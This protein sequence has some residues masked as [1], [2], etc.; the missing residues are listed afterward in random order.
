MQLAYCATQ[1]RHG[2]VLYKRHER[3]SPEKGLQRTAVGISLT[4]R[5][6]CSLNLLCRVVFVMQP[7]AVGGQ[8]ILVHIV[9]EMSHMTVDVC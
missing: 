7:G 5:S 8:S 4:R 6:G 3:F 9:L 1:I 2:P